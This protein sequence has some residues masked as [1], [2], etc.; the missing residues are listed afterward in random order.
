MIEIKVTPERIRNLMSKGNIRQATSLEAEA[1]LTV[2]GEQ[3]KDA[4]ENA[5][6]IFVAR[7]TA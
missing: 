7:K 3:L 5:V 1:F 4:I 2:H 6:K